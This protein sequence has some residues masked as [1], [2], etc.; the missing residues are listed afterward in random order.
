MNTMEQRFVETIERVYREQGRDAFF[1]WFDG[2]SN[3]EQAL[4]N[5]FF[6]F[7]VTVLRDPVP[8]H[9]SISY[10]KVALE[11][12]YGGGRLLH[13]AAHMFKEV[14]GV[15]IHPM[16]AVVDDMLRSKGLSN[17]RLYTGNGK[18]F[19]VDS[20]LVDFVYSHIVFLH[21]SGPDVLES[22]ITEV[23]RV[24]RSGG[25]ASLYYG[26]PYSFRA[27]SAKSPFIS[28]LYHTIEPFAELL[29]DIRSNGY[30]CLPDGPANSMSLMVTQRKI[31]HLAINC[32]F[33]VISLRTNRKWSQ[34]HLVLRKP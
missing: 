14:I 17:F 13:A 34:G 18:N 27:K 30:R 11:I 5:G 4:K 12:G 22:Y 3:N 28:T 10:E 20:E 15:D 7:S 8:L 9:L 29:L 26:R 1:G 24:L 6:D 25:I 2:D 16:G 21:L 23:F 33:E 32:G 19:P 31:K